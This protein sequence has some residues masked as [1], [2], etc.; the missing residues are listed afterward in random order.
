MKCFSKIFNLIFFLLSSNFIF[1]TDLG[2]KI[3]ENDSTNIEKYI[4]HIKTLNYISRKNASNPYFLNLAY[5]Y[6]DSILLIE[7]K[8]E[9]ASNTK[10][11]I[12]LTR[13]TTENNVIN[14]FKLFEFYSGTP[15][16]YGFVD[17]PIEYAYDKAIE[18]ILDN[19]YIKLHNGPLSDANIT[20]ILLRENCNDEMFEIVNQTLALNSKHHILQK[21]ELVKIFGTDKT[22]EILN[23]NFNEIDAKKLKKELK[24]D[25]LGIFKVNNLDV[26]NDEIWFVRIDFNT[27]LESGF[28]ESIFE[29]GVSID[30]RDI[31]GF[32]IITFLFYVLFFSF[33]IFLFIKYFFDLKSLD[34]FKRIILST[35]AVLI[36]VG[37]T[38][39]KS[40]RFEKELGKLSYYKR[41]FYYFL[42]PFLLSWG[43]IYFSSFILPKPEDH[44][45]EFRVILWFMCFTLM[46]SFFPLI[47]NL[48]IINRFNFDG[49]H[50]KKGY[51]EFTAISLFAT[52]FP[53]IIFHNI[54]NG[55]NFE[56]LLSWSLVIPLNMYL[57]SII[58]GA[59]FF[60]YTSKRKSKINNNQPLISLFIGLLG[61]IYIKF[62]IILLGVNDS[63][64]IIYGTPSL[65]I[66]LII[67]NYLVKINIKNEEK[68][69]ELNENN[70]QDEFNFV[71]RVIDVKNQI[72][73]SIVIDQNNDLNIYIINAN[74]GIGKSRA[75]GEAKKEFSKH[76][77]N[78]FYGDCD[79]IQSESSVSFEPI[80]QAFGHLL[81]KN[82]LSDR[83]EEIDSITSRIVNTAMDST[84]GL[85]PISEYKKDSEFTIK[86]ICLEIT[87]KLNSLDE[88][89][90]ITIEDLHWID[91]DSLAFLKELI[92]TI[93]R[94]DS[95]RKKTSLIL[96]VRSNFNNDRGIN[97][98]KLV[99]EIDQLNKETE[100]Q[101]SYKDL[102][103]TK[104]FILTDF[105]IELEKTKN[106]QNNSIRIAKSSIDE[107]NK[108]FNQLIRENNEKD[109]NVTPLYIIKNIKK[110][111][112]NETLILSQDGFILSK[113]IEIDDMPNFDEID[114]FYHDIFDSFD[115]KWIRLLE[116][117]TIIGNKFDANILSQV[118]QYNFLEVLAFLEEAVE[119]ELV[120]D[121]SD[122]DNFYEFKDQRIV[123]A[124][125]SYFKND[126]IQSSGEKQITIEYNKR[127]LNLV[128][129]IIDHPEKNEIEEVLKV[130]KRIVSLRFLEKYL[131]K[132]DKLILDIV[133][134][135]LY[136][137]QIEKL[138]VFGKYL[139][140]NNLAVVGEL[141]IDLSLISDLFESTNE[142][143]KEI[144][145][146]ISAENEIFNKSALEKNQTLKC[147]NDLRLIILLNSIYGGKGDYTF[148]ASTNIDFGFS[149]HGWSFFQYEYLTK[150]FISKISGIS[151][152]YFLNNYYEGLTK[153]SVYYYA[154]I[155]ESV[156]YY[157]R[158]TEIV[159]T[160]EN[161]FNELN[162]DFIDS[163][164]N[165][166][167]EIEKELFNLRKE[168]VS[169]KS[170]RDEKGRFRWINSLN[171]YA[172]KEFLTE[173]DYNEIIKKLNN[174]FPNKNIE[175]ISFNE[176]L[177]EQFMFQ[178]LL[179]EKKNRYNSLF[180]VVIESK[181]LHLIDKCL[182][183][184]I[185][186]SIFELQDDEIA[187]EY[188]RKYH[189]KLIINENI[190][191]LWVKRLLD[192]MGT[193][194]R[195]PKEATDESNNKNLISNPNFN[196]SFTLTNN[197]GEISEGELQIGLLYMIEFTNEVES[198]LKTA[199]IYL[200]KTIESSTLS[201]IAQMYFNIHK[202]F[203]LRFKSFKELDKLIKE[204]KFKLLKTYSN[205]HSSYTQFLKE[206]SF[207]LSA[208]KL[209]RESNKELFELLDIRKKYLSN[210]KKQSYRV[211]VN[212]DSRKVLYNISENY[213][214]LDNQ[215]ESLKYILK[216]I[217][218]YS[219]QF[220]KWKNSGSKGSM[221][222]GWE[223]K[224]NKLIPQIKDKDELYLLGGSMKGLLITWA[225]LYLQL[226]RIYCLNKDYKK[227]DGAFD[228]SL[229]YIY[230]KVMYLDYN[231][232]ML[233]KGVNMYN[234]DK[235]EAVKVLKNYIQK[236]EKNSLYKASISDS[237]S[238]K[239]YVK[240][241]LDN[242]KKL[243]FEVL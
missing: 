2:K 202:N 156:P 240:S 142:K 99:E 138:Y 210:N 239:E 220:E 133:F 25:R 168:I 50:T 128:K 207:D 211:L 203:I 18:K 63:S 89:I 175:E 182:K 130:T 200:S 223:L 27:F 37:N 73:N 62:L 176:K 119:R 69:E 49:F 121:L 141:I 162:N 109:L 188:F 154:G 137:N 81:N 6:S 79:E 19:R 113:S 85:N 44:F 9:F 11:S 236:I 87:E 204:F 10:I 54:R 159:N 17:D 194:R 145:K 48:F 35:F 150:V 33:S 234:Y 242:S 189:P 149:E 215:N 209:F 227:A 106:D 102:V 146:R 13:V 222:F 57:L 140:E 24:L 51:Q 163:Y 235:I 56:E 196:P 157:K 83:S 219:S 190:N 103:S 76:N 226:A 143:K 124:I 112:D 233:E 197:I 169:F 67:N 23:G 77:W 68:L 39:I 216:A 1:S 58:I 201:S 45:L 61:L 36:L 212:L 84:I 184:F 187:I 229:L 26:I 22:K 60:E 20:S 88:K 96:T 127:Y 78:W 82:E 171:D 144:V 125:K 16:Y 80:L 43:M 47:V 42:A 129:H 173:S 40:R 170:L 74:Q 231:L 192:F 105:L 118:W 221:K 228:E 7:P 59:A 123:S 206:I 71:E 166:T 55:W 120:I 86:N 91:S 214:K 225:G 5:K 134:R 126:L 185:H 217:D 208:I 238:D 12:D 14:K 224:D 155:N 241:I 213:K 92:K 205:S 90:I 30:K 117:A 153:L 38:F 98:K 100:N 53:F 165:K 114:S 94:Y 164:L 193:E 116:S 186:F 148:G 177:G 230:E 93:N 191:E 101:I 179:E 52:H 110:W 31:N 152:V 180:E 151:L 132:L 131:I 107:L 4:N 161:M 108:I 75:L 41:Y 195:L 115:K 167:I 136:F 72:F 199:G 198:K 29:K 232:I 174:N 139:I 178:V 3:T 135:Y 8:N 46:M 28:T 160:I 32:S 104:D 97:Y 243:I 21:D 34:F 122:E 70:K 15:N 218:E 158:K 183:D 66:C 172:L 64:T 65:I 147:I 237:Q 111:I 181:N 95:L